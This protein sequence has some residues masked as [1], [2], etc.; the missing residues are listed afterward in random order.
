[1]K[2]GIIIREACFIFSYMSIKPSIFNALQDLK[3]I[4]LH[5][6][7]YTLISNWCGIGVQIFR[8]KSFNTENSFCNY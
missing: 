2:L 3:I 7:F 6:V 8:R 5:A 1:M 4:K